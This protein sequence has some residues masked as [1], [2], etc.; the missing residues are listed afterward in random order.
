MR[1]LASQEAGRSEDWVAVLVTPTDDP[2]DET[3]RTATALIPRCRQSL[4]GRADDLRTY[5]V[6]A[7]RLQAIG[8]VNRRRRRDPAAKAVEGAS[9]PTRQAIRRRGARRRRRIRHD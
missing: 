7:G 6:S 2:E 1:H 3:L 8:A 9:N 5:L 4:R